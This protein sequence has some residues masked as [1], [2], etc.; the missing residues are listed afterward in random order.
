MSY[1]TD[2]S[3]VHGFLHTKGK[4][5]VN[6]DGEEVLLRGWGAG[7]WNNPEGFMIGAVTN[8]TGAAV[9]DKVV[10]ASGMDRGRSF[11]QIVRET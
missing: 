1:P 4:L 9:Q 11:I 10:R 6:G 8:F 3:R 7:N 5:L 2:N